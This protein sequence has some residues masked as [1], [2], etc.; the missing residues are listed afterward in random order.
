MFSVMKK[1]IYLLAAAFIISCNNDPRKALPP[2]GNFGQTVTA[3]SAIDVA[4]VITRLQTEDEFPVKVKGTITQYCKGEG[5]WMLLKNENGEDLLI[6]IED[7]AFVLPHNI[8]GKTA[9]AVG[10]AIKETQDGKEEIFISASGVL[11]Q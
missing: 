6:Q 7:N 3:D 5:C 8:D 2:T 4:A 10:K 9:T 11:I 1:I